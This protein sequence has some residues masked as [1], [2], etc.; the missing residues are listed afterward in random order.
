[1]TRKE[2]QG[3][4]ALAV[5]VAISAALGG[6]VGWRLADGQGEPDATSLPP[7]PSTESYGGFQPSDSPPKCVPSGTVTYEIY[8]S[9]ARMR[10]WV[11][12]WP[13][14]GGYSVVPRVTTDASGT[15]VPYDPPRFNYDGDSASETADTLG[16][17]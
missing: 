12:R 2:R 8:D 11:F 10:Y 5:A 4:C 3:A 7:S 17:D 1:M 13:E 15:I 6:C 9:A 16:A 14:N